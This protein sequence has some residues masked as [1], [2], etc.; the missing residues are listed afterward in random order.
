MLLPS[1]TPGGK[2][3]Q[4]HLMYKQKD[5][6]YEKPSCILKHV[7]Q[8]VKQINR[9]LYY[10]TLPAGDYHEQH[11]NKNSNVVNSHT[12]RRHELRPSQPACNTSGAVYYY[13]SDGVFWKWL[14]LCC[15]TPASPI[16]KV[17]VQSPDFQFGSY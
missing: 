14:F 5:Y 7:P 1:K 9:S 17:I 15:D 10:H 8:R 3:Y 4:T 16:P 2:S 6:I 11:N 12:W 13:C